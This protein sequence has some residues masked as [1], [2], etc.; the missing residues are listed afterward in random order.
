MN[1]R[2]PARTTVALATAAMALGLSSCSFD[3][4]TDMIYNPAIGVNDQSSSV[5]LLNLV[6]VTSS[7]SATEGTLVLTL[8]NNDTETDDQL[9]EV[10]PGGDDA[11][12]QVTSSGI[13]DIPAGQA[14]VLDSPD[15]LR[16]EGDPVTDGAFI[17]LTFGFANAESVTID[18]PVVVQSEGYYDDVETP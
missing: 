12:A 15:D 13:I 6:I 5:D 10:T 17:T 14:V 7:E 3:H 11:A 4:P 8:A 16:I 1:V 9:V 2:R 18:V